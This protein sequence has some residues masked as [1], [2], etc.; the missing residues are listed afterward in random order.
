MKQRF[1]LTLGLVLG[2]LGVSQIARGQTA[3]ELEA[4]EF[5]NRAALAAIGSLQ[6]A[7]G[8]V[9][10][11][12]VECVR[13]SVSI[14]CKAISDQT[15]LVDISE[16]RQVRLTVAA[17][18]YRV[19][20][21]TATATPAK[22]AI[23]PE[24]QARLDKCQRVLDNFAARPLNTGRQCSWEIM[25]RIVAYGIQT[26]VHR[27]GPT[28][29][30]VNAIGWIL[31]G[32][33]CNGVPLL[34]PGRDQIYLGLGPG[35]QGHQGQFLG[36]L[37]QSHVA[38]ESPFELGGRQYTIADLV[39]QEKR[40]VNSRME[41]TFKLIA[42]SYYLN[43]DDTWT[44]NDGET[45]SISRLVQEEIRQPLQNAACGG[46][47]RLFGLSSAFLMR[48]KEGLPIDG[49]F[50]RAQTYIHDYQHYTLGTLQ[51]PDGSFSTDWFNR[52]ANAPDIDRK[53]QTTGH[54]L[55]WLVFS[56]SDAELHDPRI[57][58]SIDFIANTLDAAPD[59]DWSV[60]PLGHALHALA[61]YSKRIETEGTPPHPKV[62]RQSSPR[63]SM[64]DTS[65][66]DSVAP[67]VDFLRVRAR[68]QQ[69]AVPPRPSAPMGQ[70]SARF[71]RGMALRLAHS[72]G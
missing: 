56:L 3:E 29:P 28:G 30:R 36:M 14:G 6:S 63:V 44:S 17:T 43:S 24:M 72:I 55:E 9:V 59:K 66:R 45:W 70:R 62:A 54:M 71:R 52:P 8:D 32:G 16:P 35:V 38:P 18:L 49:E 22:P 47:H 21:F 13:D 46:S 48:A 12:N 31:M 2:L 37:A 25:H 65:P 42:L 40:D 69:T 61:I 15:G 41:L 68:F 20:R 10:E 39:E 67:P 26:E 60:G 4:A 51:N 23:T 64:R 1:P 27:D 50:K 34:Q 33:R 5:P 7:L 53:I 58:K 11:D 19:V 57:T